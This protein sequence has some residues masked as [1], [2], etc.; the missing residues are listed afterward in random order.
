MVPSSA[1]LNLEFLVLELN[2]Y[3]IV[4]HEP[5][6]QKTVSIEKRLRNTPVMFIALKRARI[7]SVL[8]NLA[9][10]SIFDFFWNITRK[11]PWELKPC[12]KR[13]PA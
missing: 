1:H 9:F 4:L 12:K 10:W 2:S 3:T 7:Y 11:H 5:V 6:P 13:F 8:K